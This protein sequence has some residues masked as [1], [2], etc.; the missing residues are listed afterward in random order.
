MQNAKRDS[1]GVPGLL[2]HGPNG[3]IP[4]KATEDGRLCVQVEG[5]LSNGS[6]STPPLVAPEYNYHLVKTIQLDLETTRN[7]ELV[8]VDFD[9]LAVGNIQ[10]HLT[11]TINGFDLTI[12]KCLSM[13]LTAT[14]VLVSNVEQEGV[15]ELW[16]FKK[17]RGES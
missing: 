14:N 4:I 17:K 13:D 12:N 6:S 8:S 7:Q 11:L 2:G 15:C 5:N 1:Y 10:G 3:V 16:F 9:C